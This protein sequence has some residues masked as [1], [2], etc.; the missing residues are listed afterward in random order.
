MKRSDLT[1]GQ[2]YALARGKWTRE[3]FLGERVTLLDL[4][5]FRTVSRFLSD[6]DAMLTLADGREVRSRGVRRDRKDGRAGPFV[7]VQTYTP[8]GLPYAVKFETLASLVSRWAEYVTAREAFLRRQEARKS[9]LAAED[10][11]RRAA[12][13]ELATLATR[14]GL[15]GALHFTETGVTVTLDQLRW[16]LNR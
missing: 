6:G 3:R 11:E 9:N 5:P 15:P 12:Q 4:G 14:V 8:E 2:D 13:T 7:A 10:A 16:L 1:V